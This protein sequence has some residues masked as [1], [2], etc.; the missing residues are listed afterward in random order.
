VAAAN[1]YSN[2]RTE[3]AQQEILAIV[4][5]IRS[6]YATRSTFAA[7]VVNSDVTKVMASASVFPSDMLSGAVTT[8]TYSTYPQSPWST[9]VEI[10]VNDASVTTDAVAGG[11]FRIIVDAYQGGLPPHAG[12]SLLGRIV[13]PGQDPSLISVYCSTLNWLPVLGTKT[14]AAANSTI[15]GYDATTFAGCAPGDSIGLIFLLKG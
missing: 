11:S 6:L 15:A 8:G 12:Q 14:A 2:L 10:Y 7:A 5:N 1:V 3:K 13:G 9:P 4:Q